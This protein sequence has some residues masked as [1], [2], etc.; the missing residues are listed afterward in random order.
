MA[1]LLCST[2]IPTPTP[3]PPLP[4]EFNPDP[5]GIAGVDWTPPVKAKPAPAHPAPTGKRASLS[6]SKAPPEEEVVEDPQTPWT[7]KTTYLHDTRVSGHTCMT[8]G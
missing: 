8:H 7:P 1:S 2:S 6:R 4:Q 5:F 3:A